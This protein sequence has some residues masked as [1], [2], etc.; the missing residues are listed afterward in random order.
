LK[1]KVSGLFGHCRGVGIRVNISLHIQTSY[2]NP[3]LVLETPSTI[4]RARVTHPFSR[5]G[6]LGVGS[7]VELPSL[8][9]VFWGML[10]IN[11]LFK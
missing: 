8:E 1:A 7:D 10:L 11:Q 3:E 9:S 4:S 5:D 2:T 6:W